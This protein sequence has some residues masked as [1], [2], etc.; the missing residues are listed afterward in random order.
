MKTAKE[1]LHEWKIALENLYDEREIQ[2]FFTYFLEDKFELNRLE[3]QND[4][5]INETRIAALHIA[6]DRLKKG[7]PYQ[8][9]VGF[10]HFGSLRIKTDHRALIPRPETEELVYWIL[11]NEPQIELNVLDWCTGTGC[12]PLL[13]KA[14]QPMWNLKG[15]DWSDEALSLANENQNALKSDVSFEKQ[16]ALNIVPTEKWDVIV[17]NPPYIPWNEKQLMHRNVT[18]FE[19]DMALFVDDHD[20]LIFYRKIGEYAFTALNE[21]GSLY[22]EI[23]E[24][25]GQ[26]TLYC[27]HEI[28][29]K[30]CILRKDLQGKDR[31]IWAR[32]N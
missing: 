17:S 12:I 7:E 11:E 31:M 18:D 2:T 5:W 8:H 24:D 1:L 30:N 15:Y 23:H 28:G 6:L 16:D 4:S 19:P 26:Q 14:E 29:F 25:L 3:I 20:P 10:T 22:F 21:N 9:I 27:L 32:I 13:L